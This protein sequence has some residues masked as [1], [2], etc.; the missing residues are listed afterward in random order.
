EGIEE[1]ESSNE[2][3]FSDIL[4]EESL[5]NNGSLFVIEE[6]TTPSVANKCQSDFDKI[7]EV[8]DICSD[9]EDIQGA[10]IDNTLDSIERKNKPQVLAAWPNNAYRDY[11]ELIIEVSFTARISV[12]L[13]DMLEDNEITTTYKVARSKM[14]CHNCMV[15]YND[16]NNMNLASEKTISRTSK[17]MQQIL[18]E[19]QEKEFSIYK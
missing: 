1:Q 9:P 8:F 11:M 2:E 15:Q 5:E 19:K 18:D 12:F 4:V 7:A 3:N 16:L 13:A 17:H 10:T 14:P 6:N